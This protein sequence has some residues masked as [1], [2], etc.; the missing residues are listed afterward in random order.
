MLNLWSADDVFPLVKSK[1]IRVLEYK[2]ML[3]LY[4]IE[5]LSNVEEEFCHFSNEGVI[6]LAHFM[7]SYISI[8]F[9]GL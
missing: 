3:K 4:L 6:F 9:N 2:V 5:K 8:A 1:L 7:E